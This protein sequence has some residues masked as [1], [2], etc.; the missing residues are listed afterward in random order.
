V[1]L[2]A[3]DEHQLLVFWTQLLVLLVVARLLG[4]AMRRI[5]QPAVVGQ[6]GAGLLLGP[7]LLGRVAPGVLDWL[8][9]ADPLQSGMLFAVS[10]IG[11]LLLLI[12]TGFETDL[13]LIR[14]LGKATALVSAGSIVLPLIAGLF[15]GT[16]LPDVFR[17][18]LDD[19]TVFALFVGAA[20][21]ISSLAVAG[22]VLSDLGLMRRNFGQVT[23]AAG[24]ANDVV[25]WIMLGIVAA[26]ASAGEI[27]VGPLL[28]TVVG[29]A[30]L[31]GGGLTVGQRV[32]DYVLREV[33]RR[34]VTPT[35]YVTV[36]LV[37]ALVFGVATQLIGAEAV[38]GAFVAG[39]VVARSKFHQPEARET[40]ER[41]TAGVFAPIFFATAGLRVDLGLLADPEVL[42]WAVVV[43]GAASATKFVGAYL[44]AQVAGLPP[45]EGVL[46]GIG[47]NPR[48]TLEIVIAT[49]GL[50]LGVF[51]Q[52]S[53]TVI[54]LMA[55]LNSMAA[56]PLLR[57]VA[58]SWLGTDEEQKR[59]QREE[60]VSHN[61]MVRSHRLLLPSQGGS[62]S[63]VAAQL[64]HFAWLEDV[65]ATVLSV[66][67]DADEAGV[68]AVVDI[69]DD[70]PVSVLRVTSD[71]ASDAILGEARLGYGAIGIG[72]P[73]ASQGPWILSPI[74]DKL[75][76]QTAIP[77]IIVRR[78][79][80]LDRPLPGA[81]A[82]A[83]VP[84]SAAPWSRAAQEIAFNL[85]ANIGTEIVLTH[86]ATPSTT[87]SGDARERRAGGA[88]EV[89]DP[90]ADVSG[91][92][93][94]R[95][96]AFAEEQGARARTVARTGSSP[97]EEIIA[98]AIEEQADLVVLGANLRRIEGRPFLSTLVEQV[99][100]ECDATV[101]VVATPSGPHG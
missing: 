33:R 36:V 9:P 28:V 83:L 47:L 15:V 1:N 60:S 11:I 10:W 90:R 19:P 41:I 23:L 4:Q 42:F 82:R 95:A 93:T 43:I 68:Q 14:R 46:L 25:G 94:E 6:L 61:V 57:G 54:L 49:V 53:Y 81:F 35:G 92:L 62:N 67:P 78:A 56:P 29:I 52:A 73:E 26:L 2:V 31:Y 24:M 70:R 32:V 38:L 50:S 65:E 89:A 72:A 76:Y 39:I 34:D 18:E 69:F 77:L 51:N 63:I 66:G 96:E 74:V 75:L 13:A 97:A 79:R 87:A 86:V 20:L 91:K 80:N 30:V 58:R 88:T 100:E 59:L 40:L 17:G 71:D 7:S 27:A 8:V 22:K 55:I 44:G 64:L 5:G 45:R 101:V 16:A 99:L 48:G 37:I 3:P 21:S 12:E 84:V 85:S 98:A